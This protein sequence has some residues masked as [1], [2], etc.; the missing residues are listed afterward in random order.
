M[1]QPGN[2]LGLHSLA[3]L[4]ARPGCTPRFLN[5]QSGSGTRLLM[6][7]LLAEQGLAAESITGWFHPP[8]DSHLAVAAALAGGAADA[9]P[10]IEAAARAFGLGFV[11]LID[12]DYYLVCLKDTLEHPAVLKLRAA[13]EDPAWMHA[14]QAVA[15]YAPSRG[16]QVLS[17]TQALPWWHFRTPK[18][19]ARAVVS[20][21]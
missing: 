2:P 17:L 10:G 1:V 14:L 18:A 7:H 4:Q 8:E 12:E 19:S 9:G 13:L 16:G 11:P 3:D 6:D 21:G 20:A 5:R 15:G